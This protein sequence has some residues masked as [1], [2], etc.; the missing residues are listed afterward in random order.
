MSLEK[1]KTVRAQFLV[2]ADF[3]PAADQTRENIPEGNLRMDA[4][5]GRDVH[6]NQV[7]LVRRILLR[8]PVFQDGFRQD[9]RTATDSQE[10]MVLAVPHGGMP[11]GSQPETVLQAAREDL[12][13]HHEREG[14]DEGEHGQVG[15]Q[16]ARRPEDDRG[17]DVIEDY[18]VSHEHFQPGHQGGEGKLD[19]VPVR[20]RVGGPGKQQ[21]MDGRT[22]GEQQAEYESHPPPVA[23]PQEG[24]QETDEKDHRD[25]EAD[26][27][28]HHRGSRHGEIVHMHRA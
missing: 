18:G 12:E 20:H 9:L 23:L 4:F 26:K 8:G 6:E 24:I 28:G 27:P 13:D 17:D 25:G 16:Q 15:H 11:V 7:S 19:P 14:Q 3:F 22:Q 5:R 1:D 21:D 10:D 2:Q